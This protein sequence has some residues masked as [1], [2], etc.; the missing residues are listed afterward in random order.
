MSRPADVLAAR[1]NSWRV[2]G[3]RIHVSIDPALPNCRSARLALLA[4]VLGLRGDRRRLPAEDPAARQRPRRGRGGRRSC[5]ARTTRTGSNSFWARPPPP[6]P[7]ATT[8]GTTSPR[9]PAQTAFFDPIA[10]DQGV[11]AITFDWR[12]RRRGHESLRPGRWPHRGD[13]RPHHAD[14]RQRADH[15]PAVAGQFRPLQPRRITARTQA[16][17]APPAH[18]AAC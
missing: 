2:F 12:G 18:P 16:R 3:K 17:P 4:G 7:S 10:I 14:P 13:G 6:A 11:L 1:C 15:H 9:V 5:R 8:F